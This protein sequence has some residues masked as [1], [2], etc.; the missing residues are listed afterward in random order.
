M[1]WFPCLAILALVFPGNLHS[2]TPPQ[3]TRIDAILDRALAQKNI[4]KNP[5]V[6]DEI[7]LRRIYLDAIGRAPAHAEAARFLSSDDPEKRSKLIDELLASE[8]YVN[9]YF[10]FWADLLRIHLARGGGTRVTPYYIEFVR[11]SLRENLPYDEFVRQLV[12]AE[13]DVMKHGAA[14]FT[15]RDR[16]MP[17]DHLANTVRIFLGTRLECAQC[18]N[19]PFDKWTQLDFF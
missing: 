15:Y 1:K 16:G 9:H 18:H 8:G 7:F 2:K 13:G 17:L 5:V 12:A 19:H 14:G 4:R 11:Q 10:N 6:G 3:S